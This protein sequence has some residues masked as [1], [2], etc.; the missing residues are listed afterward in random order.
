[1]TNKKFYSTKTYEHSVGLSTCFR[2]WKA[3]SH[4]RFL[5]GYALQVKLIFSST[6]LDNNGWVLDFGGLKEIKQWLADNFDHKTVVAEDDPAIWKF[7]ELAEI[8]LIDLKVIPHVGMERFAEYIF[9]HVSAWATNALP[10]DSGVV[11]ESVEVR[12]HAGNSA[13][14]ER[15]GAVS[16]K[17]LDDEIPF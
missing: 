16:S 11:L 7:R 12:E 6:E 10:F 9:D 5:H 8:D 14:C 2:Q 17:D 4:C 13:I 1:M 3:E 15:D